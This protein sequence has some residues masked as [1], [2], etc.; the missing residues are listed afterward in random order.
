MALSY[1]LS[2]KAA[3]LPQSTLLPHRTELPQS[4]LLPQRT[5]LPQRTLLPQRTE[6]PQRTLLPWSELVAVEGRTLL[7]SAALRPQTIG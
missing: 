2:F 3:V 6:L 4:T 5:E 7:T 1:Q